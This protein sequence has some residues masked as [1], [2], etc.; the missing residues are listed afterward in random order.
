VF[1]HTE[2]IVIVHSYE[3][4]LIKEN[5]T[6]FCFVKYTEGKYLAKIAEILESRSEENVLFFDDRLVP[7]LNHDDITNLEGWLSINGVKAIAPRVNRSDMFAIDCGANI[8][9]DGIRPLFAGSPPYHQAAMGNVEWVRNLR[10]LNPYVFVSKSKFIQA[11][12]KSV[13]TNEVD[14]E[15][16]HT[17]LHLKLSDKGRLV[18]NPKTS[19]VARENNN[20]NVHQYYLEA[21][22]LVEASDKD[23]YMNPNLSAEDPMM[24]TRVIQ[25]NES[26][27]PISEQ[28]D[29]YQNE[30][31]VHALSR[32]LTQKELVENYKH[33]NTTKRDALKRV[34]TALIILPDFSAI[35]AGLN[36]IF[37]FADNLSKK[38]G[39]KITFALMAAD[40]SLDRQRQLVAEK[41]PELAKCSEFI[42]INSSNLDKLPA[43]DVAVCTQWATAY[44]LARYNKSKRKCY[45]IQDKEA[46]FY[47]KGSISALVD[48][49]YTFGFYALANT[50]GL[51]D[52]YE[53]EF[54]GLGT[55]LRSNIDLTAYS[56]PKTINTHPKAPYKVFFYARPNEPRNAFEIGVASMV[57][58]KKRLGSDLEIYAAGADWNP[59][60]YGLQDTLTNLGKISYDT[61]PSF[62]RDM[63][64]G[65]MLMFSGHPGVVASELMASGTPVVVNTYEDS[66]WHDLYEDGKTAIVS[67]VTADAIADSF[68]KALKDTDLRNTLITNG[69]SKAASFYGGYQ[70][71]F[72]HAIQDLGKANKP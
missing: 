7:A 69:I 61:L 55:T 49:T 26:D 24:I 11:A 12:I 27:D 10:V 39:T 28:T 48:N 35:Y 54:D 31:L 43:V 19:V 21:T 13:K 30:A 4:D 66:T 44:I 16:A 71:S 18:F 36:N 52:W 6:H 60:D 63:D 15:I 32:R 8:T 33:I 58:L 68:E 67:R 37:F 47:P 50:E 9:T 3:S 42:G 53:K 34:H 62:Y 38:Q 20:I 45:F 41:Y 14:D 59:I 64:A 57:E 1:S 29:G 25:S 5:K 23:P 46:S 17:A 72:V 65:M 40:K 70:E 56:P 2:N 22:S 51:L